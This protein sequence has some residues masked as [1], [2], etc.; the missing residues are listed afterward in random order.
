MEIILQKPPSLIHRQ[1]IVHFTKR[2]LGK[3]IHRQRN[4]TINYVKV[5]RT[6][7][8]TINIL[9][10]TKNYDNDDNELMMTFNNVFGNVTTLG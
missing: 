5:L 9:E 2:K 3:K 8:I 1:S 4:F 6:L 7:G 10:N